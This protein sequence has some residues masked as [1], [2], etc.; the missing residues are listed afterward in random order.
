[1]GFTDIESREVQDG[2]F[3]SYGTAVGERSLGMHLEVDV[4]D[5]TERF[6]EPNAFRKLD[7]LSQN[8]LSS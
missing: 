2:R 5:E 6:H 3:L 1:M 4:V 7:G 8:T